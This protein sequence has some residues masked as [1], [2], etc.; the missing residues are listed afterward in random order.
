MKEIM[1]DLEWDKILQI[2]L[3]FNLQFG[4]YITCSIKDEH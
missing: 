4:F 1:L 2:I 3:S